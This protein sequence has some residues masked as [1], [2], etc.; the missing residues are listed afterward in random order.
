MAIAEMSLATDAHGQVVAKWLDASKSREVVAAVTT[1]AAEGDSRD[2]LRARLGFRLGDN[3][4]MRRPGQDMLH[5]VRHV[6]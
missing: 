5:H 2:Y 1:E 3:N 6:S 4:P